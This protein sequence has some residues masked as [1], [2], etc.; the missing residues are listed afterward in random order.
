[1]PVGNGLGG[2][3][4]IIADHVSVTVS[5]DLLETGASC[6]GEDAGG[7]ARLLVHCSGCKGFL[8]TRTQRVPNPAVPYVT[9]GE[10]YFANF[11]C[12]HLVPDVMSS[13]SSASSST[14]VGKG[15]PSQ[16]GSSSSSIA[17]TGAGA[18]PR[19]TSTV[20][21][22]L[23][24]RGASRNPNAPPQ[25][26]KV[27]SS[28]SPVPSKT[29][30]ASHAKPVALSLL[31]SVRLA[32]E[33]DDVDDEDDDD[34]DESGLLC[35]D[36]F[37]NLDVIGTVDGAEQAL[38]KRRQLHQSWR[39]STPTAAAAAPVTTTTTTSA[40]SQPTTV[41]YQQRHALR[42]EALNEY[43]SEEDEEDDD[44]DEGDD[45]DQDGDA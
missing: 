25:Q 5:L 31:D 41:S 9:T 12:L 43:S 30:T 23:P 40:G 26:A 32:A 45:E 3:Q 42:M 35:E 38:A 15:T 2:F 8:G 22:Q 24:A 33:A 1:M 29:P 10:V 28:P 17:T 13:T 34:D 21:V 27:A 11:S 44:D 7:V 20:T 14:A 6:F 18:P 4:E 16:G 37:D 19:K 39:T 36:D